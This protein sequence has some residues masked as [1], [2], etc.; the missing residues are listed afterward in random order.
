MGASF[1]Q[2][3]S[4][5]F[6]SSKA[7]SNTKKM[8]CRFILLV[9]LLFFVTMSSLVN[10]TNGGDFSKEDGDKCSEG[11]EC[12]SQYCVSRTIFMTKSAL[13][14]SVHSIITQF[15]LTFDQLNRK[16]EFAPNSF[17]ILVNRPGEDASVLSIVLMVSNHYL[18]KPPF[19]TIW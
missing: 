19:V 7:S 13:D 18:C 6:Q 8:N 4:Y 10:Y 17:R 9:S 3:E 5:S 12:K 1:F 14:Q 11:A 15:I 16:K 2:F